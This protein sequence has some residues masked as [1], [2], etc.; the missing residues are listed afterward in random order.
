[1]F[2]V[3][4][5]NI[6]DTIRTVKIEINDFEINFTY[7]HKL[8]N[9][10]VAINN[11]NF[12]APKITYEKNDFTLT[13][14]HLIIFPNQRQEFENTYKKCIKFCNDSKMLIDD[15]ID[16]IKNDQEVKP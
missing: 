7:N 16:K 14:D 1:M 12:I 15:I 9:L 4:Y 10:Y 11:N 2:T 3:I 13:F 8:K 5:D 6:I